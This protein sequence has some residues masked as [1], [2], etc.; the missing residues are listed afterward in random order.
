MKIVST[1]NID[2]PFR[3]VSKLYYCHDL[4]PHW[5]PG[6]VSLELVSTDSQP[7]G[8]VFRQKYSIFNNNIVEEITILGLDLPHHIHLIS[9]LEFGTRESWIHFE[10]I[11][12][13]SSR[14]TITNQFSESYWNSFIKPD[15]Q[16][17][18][19]NFLKSFKHFIEDW[20]TK[21]NIE[22]HSCCQS[23]N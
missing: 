14:I 6:F 8:S 1:I 16:E 9:S 2:L 20:A 22:Q 17:H 3:L 5:F 12:E 21:E 19:Q 23:H 13:S 15:L 10:P 4:L 11:E 18:S 7:L